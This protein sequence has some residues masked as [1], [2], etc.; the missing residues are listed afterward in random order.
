VVSNVKPPPVA[1]VSNS[2]FAAATLSLHNYQGSWNVTAPSIPLCLDLR[3]AQIAQPL[4]GNAAR[5][6]CFGLKPLLIISYA[7]NAAVSNGHLEPGMELLTKPFTRQRTTPPEL[8]RASCWSLRRR[9]LPKVILPR[10][11]GAFEA[12]FELEASDGRAEYEIRGGEA[13]DLHGRIPTTGGGYGHQHGPDS[14]VGGSRTGH[15]SHA[16][17]TLAAALQAS[18]TGVGRNAADSAGVAAQ[19]RAG[20]AR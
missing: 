5:L 6:S 11:R 20:A 4:T 18:G 14:N 2:G 10:F 17:L 8:R 7:E 9:H 16:D 3:Q 15:P 1:T 12:T 19:A 13:A